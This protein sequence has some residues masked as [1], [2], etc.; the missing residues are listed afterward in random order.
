MSSKYAW[1]YH[2]LVCST[3]ARSSPRSCNAARAAQ[4]AMTP[5]GG[6]CRRWRSAIRRSATWRGK[7]ATEQNRSG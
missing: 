3:P 1:M 7:L 2:G 4:R 5:G 6:G